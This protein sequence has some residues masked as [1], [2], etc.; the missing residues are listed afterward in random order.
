M[1]HICGAIGFDLFLMSYVTLIIAVVSIGSAQFGILISHLN[2]LCAFLYKK[3]QK[4]FSNYFEQYRNSAVVSLKYFEPFNQKYG[5]IFI[6]FVAVNLPINLY[7]VMSILLGKFSW[8]G[9]VFLF[10]NTILQ[11]LCMFTV[12]YKLV[13]FTFV[14]YRPRTL[15]LNAMAAKHGHKHYCK[16]S[17]N[18]FRESF[19][20][21]QWISIL[22]NSKK[23]VGMSYGKFG[24]CQ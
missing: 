15:L 9:L 22:Q 4:R 8:K 12:H 7:I 6:T 14:F 21:E 10:L 1:G 17:I 16:K 3:R 23:L 24:P 11:F 2:E 20:V 13:D 18:E 19:K 5:R